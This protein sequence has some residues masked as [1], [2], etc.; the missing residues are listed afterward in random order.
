MMLHNERIQEEIKQIHMLNFCLY[1][2]KHILGKSAT[3]ELHTQA[4]TYS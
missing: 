2:Q 1:M 3:T 4:K